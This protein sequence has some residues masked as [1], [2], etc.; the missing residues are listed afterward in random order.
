MIEQT[1]KLWRQ[2]AFVY[3]ETDCLLSVG[4]YIALCGGPDVPA[5]F[6][7]TYDDA[8]GAM[9]HVAAHGGP[10]AIIRLCGM[11][12]ID[13]ADAQ[14]GDIVIMDPGGGQMVLGGICTG[15]GVAARAER[16]VIEVDRRFVTLTH[17][18]SIASCRA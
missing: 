7:G 8:A 3:G 9:R 10:E 17:A 4:D 16:G 11:V 15:P 13:P 1:L 2:S 12:E 5:R 18:W 14:R 6:R